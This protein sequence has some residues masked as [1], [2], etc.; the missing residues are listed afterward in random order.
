MDQQKPNGRPTAIVSADVVKR[1]FK[2]S[3]SPESMPSAVDPAE[4]LTE[5]QRQELLVKLS[6]AQAQIESADLGPGIM[7]SPD[8]ALGARLQSWIAENAEERDAEAAALATREIQFDERDLR[9]GTSLLS[10][11]GKVTKEDQKRPTGGPEDLPSR[12]RIGIAGDWGSGLYGSRAVG[13]QL[14]DRGYTYAIHLGD[15]YYAGTERE[16]MT[17]FLPYWPHGNGVIG[18]TLNSNHEMYSGGHGY[19]KKALPALGQESSYFA[20]RN[21]DWLILALDTG[22]DE[23]DLDARQV[24][25]IRQNVD[26]AGARRVILMSHHQPFSELEKGGP[27]LVQAL[28]PLLEAHKVSAWYWGHEHCAFIYDEHPAWKLQGRCIGHG[29]FPY[30]RYKGATGLKHV[31]QQ[32][33]SHW[34]I[35]KPSARSPGGR[36]LD[37]PNPYVAPEAEPEEYGAQGYASLVF[38][39]PSLVEH[40]HRP[41]GEIIYTK[42]LTP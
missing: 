27:K 29:G 6:A 40:L 39:G 11:L 7:S 5:E 15:V 22:Y 10:W 12:C 34:R 38:D 32:G 16:V 36:M 18:R 30:F 26:A 37:D 14:A 8:A 19:F 35:F 13:T 25:W 9:W 3:A 24:E 23:H 42:Q 17:R 4:A 41:T 33:S 20:L 31:S 1:L 2:E 28:E 21:A